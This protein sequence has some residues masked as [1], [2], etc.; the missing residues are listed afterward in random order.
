MNPKRRERLDADPH[1]HYCRIPLDDDNS[2]L[3]HVVPRS[4][5]GAHR[6]ENLVLAC[7]RC[8]DVKQDIPLDF[9]IVRHHT[10]GGMARVWDTEREKDAGGQ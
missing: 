7:R 1:C 5:G 3:D 2:S 10:Q 8:Q 9:L 4:R 6:P